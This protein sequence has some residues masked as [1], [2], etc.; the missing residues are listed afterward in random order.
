MQ[1]MS[2]YFCRDLH[3]ED[4]EA[5]RESLLTLDDHKLLIGSLQY[6]AKR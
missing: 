5:Q 4:P 2:G 3:F 6:K 1:F